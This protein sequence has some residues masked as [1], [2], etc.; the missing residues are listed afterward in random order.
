MIKVGVT[1]ESGFIGTHLC[2][3]LD[4]YPEKYKRIS[5]D[6]ESFNNPDKL[7]NIISQ[8]D[9]IFH[10]AA[11]N[12]HQN[13]EKIYETNISLVKKLITACER[14]QSTPHVLFS[15]STQETKNN[16]YGKSKKDGRVLFEAW[17]KRNNSKFT[18]LVIPNV[19]GPFGNPYYNSVVATF[20][21]QLANEEK[22]EI[23]SDSNLKLI[24]VGELVSKFLDLIDDKEEIERIGRFEVKN[25]TEIMVSELLSTLKKI[26]KSYFSNGVVPSLETNFEKNLFNTFLC[27]VDH[28]SFF[29]FLLEKN[30]DLR[31]NFV[32]IIRLNSGGQISFSTTVSGVTRGNHFHT[33]KAERFTV[34]KGKALIEIRQIGTKLVKS[35]ELDGENPSF[36]DMPIWYTHNIKN[37]GSEDLYTIFWINEPYDPKD[38]DTYF[39]DVRN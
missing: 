5:F 28:S 8:C 36:V 24:Y 4:L 25:T 17:A 31:G 10:L 27:Y 21:Y 35:F 33:R 34:I 12:R 39:E 6:K 30:S 29:P 20:C 1:G 18:G 9:V 7:E 26:K 16:L 22:T 15:S 13:Q 2:N 32:E 11:M 23:N 38:S 14:T 19:F 37:V 3:T